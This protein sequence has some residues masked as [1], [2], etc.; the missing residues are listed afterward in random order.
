METK[1]VYNYNGNQPSKDEGKS[2]PNVIGC[3][4]LTIVGVILCLILFRLCSSCNDESDNISKT[5][6]KSDKEKV[7][8]NNT[9]VEN[10][11]DIPVSPT[12]REAGG[13]LWT[14]VKLYFGQGETKTYIG[15]VMGGGKDS[16]GNKM[17]L[18]Q[19]DGN[20]FWK[21]RDHILSSYYYIKSNDPALIGGKWYEYEYK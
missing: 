9:P 16:D 1:Y 17:V 8:T 7:E 2:P 14:G 19:K 18:I 15:E 10:E 12:W 21:K 20:E 5:V 11:P 3:G 6:D 4:I 13:G